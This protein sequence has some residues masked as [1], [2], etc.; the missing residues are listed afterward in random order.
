MALKRIEKE[1]KEQYQQL[2]QP[3]KEEIKS[4]EKKIQEIEV[5]SLKN[6]KIGKY[7]FFLV[8]NLYTD[9]AISYIKMNRLSMHIM[10]LKQDEILENARK[11]LYNAIANLEK[12]VG[13]TIDEDLNDVSERL[14]D[15]P[16]MT[17][18]RKLNLFKK[19]EYTLKILSEELEGGKWKY[20][21][22]E[23]FS[24]FAVV[25]KNSINFR[26]LTSMDPMNP[27]Y[28]YY[29]ELVAYAKDLLRKSA[30]EYRE[31][32]EISGHEVPDMRK[33]QEFLKA[34]LRI[35]NVLSQYD[36]AKE[37]KKI[38]ETWNKKM[39]EDLKIKEKRK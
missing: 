31:K 27:N 20:K 23:M 30:D 9:I 13:S 19:I 6:N 8:A 7:K 17:P 29:N 32:Y 35:C 34:I 2:S 37:V 18:Y 15:T 4:L 14:K 28:K 21:L 16:Q 26:E 25:V 24:K 3:I 1:K 5:S 11:A 39:E 22:L 10:D 12:L 33:A 36:E 38:I